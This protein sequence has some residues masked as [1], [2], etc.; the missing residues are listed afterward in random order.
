MIRA[1]TFDKQLM[2]SEDFAHIT[3]YF[4][5]GKMGVT[6][7]CEISQDADGNIVIS[8]GYFSVYGRYLKIEGDEVIEV[9]DIP[10]GTLYSILVFEIDLSQ[11]NT[12]DEFN[13]G[14]FRI[15]SDAS[16]YPELIQEDLDN[17]GTIYQMEFCRFENTVAGISNL[18]DTRTILSLEM[19]TMQDDFN[20][21]KQDYETHLAE[22]AADNVHGATSEADGNTIMARSSSGRAKVRHPSSVDDILNV[23]DIIIGSYTTGQTEVSNITMGYSY[24]C[25]I[26]ID[27]GVSA[28][29]ARQG[30]YILRRLQGT[31]D[32]F[33]T[34]ILPIDDLE[35]SMGTDLKV[36]VKNISGSNRSINFRIIGLGGV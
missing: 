8:D 34:P 31:T 6:K 30:M 26:I 18:L 14:R 7:G 24:V 29:V 22:S 36:Y 3:R 25:L 28:G 10:S 1:I 17:G 13:Q 21:L 35:V 19:Y 33:I 5:Q 9:P 20:D 11:E 4:Y 2:K 23:S 15:I 27:M 32:Y 12:I 16:D